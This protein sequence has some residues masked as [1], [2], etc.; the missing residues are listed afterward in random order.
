MAYPFGAP[1]ESNAQGWFFPHRQLK[2]LIS[3]LLPQAKRFTPST[4]RRTPSRKLQFEPLEPRLLLS[5]DLAFMADPG[6][7]D[8]TVKLDTIDDIETVVI[9]DND[10]ADPAAKTIPGRTGRIGKTRHHR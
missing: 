3:S 4:T 5:A 2:K 10:I 8:L 7:S 1:P 9:I 6:G